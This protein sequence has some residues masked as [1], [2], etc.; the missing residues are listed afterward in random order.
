MEPNL[1]TWMQAIS[2]HWFSKIYQFK[3]HLVSIMFPA[4][5]TFKYL[6]V[7]NT[8]VSAPRQLQ[9]VRGNPDGDAT[10]RLYYE[11]CQQRIHAKQ[12]TTKN[13][14]E[15]TTQ[16][17]RSRQWGRRLNDCLKMV[18]TFSG[19]IARFTIWSHHYILTRQIIQDVDNFI[20]SILLKQQQRL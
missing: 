11:N 3:V 19:Y 15:S 9:R 13:I 2:S 8:Y 18:N 5:N 20:H 16:Q 4:I 1:S 7:L 17:W 14:H 6:Y 10:W 12:L